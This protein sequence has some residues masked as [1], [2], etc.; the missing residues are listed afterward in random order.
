M[1]IVPALVIMRTYG[2]IVEV[3]FLTL[4]SRCHPGVWYRLGSVK[5]MYCNMYEQF[6]CGT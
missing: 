6:V 3:L 1:A 2:I 4:S 5:N